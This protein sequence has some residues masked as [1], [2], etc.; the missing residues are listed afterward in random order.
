MATTTP[1][2]NSQIR[3]LTREE[4]LALLD[5]EARRRLCMSAEE[6][7]RAWDAGQFDD[8]PDRPDVMYVAMLLPFAR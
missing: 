2:T 5:R 8:D 7:I 1:P 6:F 4:G 3:E